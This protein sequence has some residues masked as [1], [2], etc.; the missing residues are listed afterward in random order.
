MKMVTWDNGMVWLEF[1]LCNAHV[2]ES[3]SLGN[4]HVRIHLSPSVDTS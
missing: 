4:H 2:Y 3:D 1:G